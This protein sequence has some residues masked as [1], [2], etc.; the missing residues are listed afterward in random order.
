MMDDGRITDKLNRS[1]SLENTIIIMTS[2]I[3]SHDITKNKFGFISQNYEEKKDTIQATIKAELRNFFRPEFLNRLGNIVIFDAL[4]RDDLSKIFELQFTEVANAIKNG[5]NVKVT[6][7][8]SAKEKILDLVAEE[9]NSNA[10]PM[11]RLIR[12]NV[13]DLLTDEI[14]EHDGK[15]TSDVVVKYDSKFVVNYEGEKHVTADRECVG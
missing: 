3:G 2:N 7:D 10:R 5:F 6:L 4:K 13:E 11:R 8:P 1:V 14:I 12:D 15:L 9:K